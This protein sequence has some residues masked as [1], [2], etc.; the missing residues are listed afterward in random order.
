MIVA[1]ILVKNEANFIWYSV[2][3]ILNF[4]DKV[5]LW[6][7]GS[8]DGTLEI[9]NEIIKE[10][11]RKKIIFK[12]LNLGFF[13]EG[14][15]RQ[16]MLDETKSDWFIVVDGDEIWWNS[17]IQEV[18][19]EINKNGR[20][21][22]SIV[23]PTINLVGDIFHYQEKEAGKYK[24]LGMK[25]HYNLRAINRRIPGLKSYGEHGV[26]GWVDGENKMIQDRDSKNIKFVNAPYLHATH[27]QRAGKRREDNKVFKRAF[28]L[29]H[30]LGIPFANDFYYP[31]VFFR[32][33]P[34]IVPNVWKN[35]DFGFRM[36]AF[37]E[38]PL[39]KLKRR[40]LPDK[41]GY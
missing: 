23:V 14:Q 25:G 36:Q 3:S 31:E 7:T 10:D 26:W 15:V 20:E 39:R 12:K 37:F 24:L 2:M 27:L 13:D 16:Q 19:D 17:S 29:K 30:E 4:V 9:I 8:S 11:K 38:T 32:N 1:H 28:K 22:E 34:E 40:I 21:L 5:M 35:M 33:R 6:D 41:V 18:T